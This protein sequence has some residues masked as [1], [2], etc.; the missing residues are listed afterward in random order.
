VRERRDCRSSAVSTSTQLV[1]VAGAARARPAGV[2]A[3]P[4]PLASPMP[5]STTLRVTLAVLGAYAVTAALPR[6]LP[7][8]GP[9]GTIELPSWGTPAPDPACNYGGQPYYFVAT[10]E[11][12]LF[13]AT[14]QA[15][16]MRAF[17]PR[18]QPRPLV[19]QLLQ[20]NA[21]GD[22][23]LS[24]ML[25]GDRCWVTLRSARLTPTQTSGGFRSTLHP[26]LLPGVYAVR[27]DSLRSLCRS[28]W[29]RKRCKF[30]AL[31]S[32]LAVPA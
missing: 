18:C 30:L 32:M 14:P 26:M 24:I 1:L 3:V 25:Y 16:D 5:I 20:A 21:T 31:R 6:I 22:R 11:A 7:Q 12:V 10:D 13:N 8:Q 4:A 15:Y 2:A 23:Q 9:K 27:H 19:E 29:C 28:S 17:E